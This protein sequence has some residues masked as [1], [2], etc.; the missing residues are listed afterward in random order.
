M[1]HELHRRLHEQD[2]DQLLMLILMV[3]KWLFIYWLLVRA[4]PVQRHH[5]TV[6]NPEYPAELDGMAGGGRHSLL[7]VGEAH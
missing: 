1:L 3:I 7:F 4:C 6:V 2:H 5:Q